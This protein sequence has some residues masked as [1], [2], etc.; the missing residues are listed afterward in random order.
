MKEAAKQFAQYMVKVDF[1]D[2]TIPLVNNIGANKVTTNEEIKNSLEYQISSPVQWWPS[3]QH[4]K[5]CDIIIEV[6]PGQVYT[7]MLQREWPDKE[8]FTIN[9]H[10][11]IE[12]LLMKLGKSIARTLHDESCSNHECA[13]EDII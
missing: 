1:K 10:V 8:I 9:N 11:D 4:F 6:G 7:K 12:N 3:M 13:E 5:D 2:L